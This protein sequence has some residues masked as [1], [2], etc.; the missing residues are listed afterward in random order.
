MGKNGECREGKEEEKREKVVLVEVFH[1]VKDVGGG[2][3][4]TE[5]E[6]GRED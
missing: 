6:D 4:R 3:G 5:E 1:G 2:G